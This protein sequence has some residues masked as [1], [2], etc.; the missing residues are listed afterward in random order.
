[1]VLHFFDCALASGTIEAR[2]SQ[3]MAWVETERLPDYE[4]PPAD[5]ALIRTLAARIR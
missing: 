2:E 5:Q 1:M 4:F 3:A